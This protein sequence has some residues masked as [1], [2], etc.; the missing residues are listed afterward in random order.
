M[1]APGATEATG[2]VRQDGHP[3]DSHLSRT[4]SEDRKHRSQPA[5]LDETDHGHNDEG[6]ESETEAGDDYHEEDDDDDDDDDSEEDEDEEPRLKYAY[7]TKHLGAVYRN[8]DA[9]SA[10][11]AAGDKMVRSYTGA[12]KKKTC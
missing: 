7:L 9:T 1:D 11:L 2:T 8:G 10:F 4:T 5:E 6:T 12:D 3:P